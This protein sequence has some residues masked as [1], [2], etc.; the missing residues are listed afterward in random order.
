MSLV[1]HRGLLENEV[2]FIRKLKSTHGEKCLATIKDSV[3]GPYILSK[4]QTRNI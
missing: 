3:I 1:T 4:R 2:N